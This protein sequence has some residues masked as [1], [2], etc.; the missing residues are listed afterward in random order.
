MRLRL[1]IVFIFDNY[2]GVECCDVEYSI[3]IQ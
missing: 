2:L 1:S 3:L